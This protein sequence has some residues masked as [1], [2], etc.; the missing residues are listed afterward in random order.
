MRHPSE[1]KTTYACSCFYSNEGQN[2]PFYSNQGNAETFNKQRTLI[3]TLC[4]FSFSGAG[5]G[6][7]VAAPVNGFGKVKKDAPPDLWRGAG[8]GAAVKA[9]DV[10]LQPLRANEFEAAVPPAVPG[11]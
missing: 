8:G 3:S 4:N 9:Q 11:L 1:N 10:E 6:A 7:Y 5:K 2:P